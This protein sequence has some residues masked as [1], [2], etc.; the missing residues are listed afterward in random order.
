MTTT[1]ECKHHWIIEPATGPIS[2]GV[3]EFCHE[4]REFKNTIPEVS[5]WQNKVAW[6]KAHPEDGVDAWDGAG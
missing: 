4:S 6:A 5:G 3:C 1:L 2:V